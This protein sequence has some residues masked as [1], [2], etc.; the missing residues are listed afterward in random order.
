LHK[1]NVGE[2]NKQ[3]QVFLSVSHGGAAIRTFNIIF[4]P[5]LY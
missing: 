4:F 5:S 3:A 1:Q 2:T